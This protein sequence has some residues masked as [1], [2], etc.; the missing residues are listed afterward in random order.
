MITPIPKALFIG[1]GSTGMDILLELRNLV[2]EEFG[3]YKLPVF[4]YLVIETATV[5]HKPRDINVKKL[6]VPDTAKIQQVL[7]MPGNKMTSRQQAMTQWVDQNL[8]LRYKS[9]MDGAE[10]C[11][12]GGRL[13]LWDCWNE[14]EKALNDASD[15]LRNTENIAE[16]KRYLLEHYRKK[17]VEVKD[18]PVIDDDEPP[19][20]YVFGTLCGGTCSGMLL[21]IGFMLKRFFPKSRRFGFFTI[22]KPNVAQGME[23]PA[24]NCCGALKEINY[25]YHPETSWD[26][27]LPDGKTRATPSM[28]YTQPYEL[29]YFVSPS[30]N[31]NTIEVSQ[32]SQMLGLTLFFDSMCAHTFE[33]AGTFADMPGQPGYQETR[34]GGWSRSFHSFG[35]SALWYPKYRISGAAACEL[36]LDLCGY[37]AGHQQKSEKDLVASTKLA[38]TEWK[39]LW[40]FVQ[41]KV[42]KPGNKDQET[43]VLQQIRDVITRKV[44][45]ENL[46]QTHSVKMHTV[47]EHEELTS[48]LRLMIN[49]A[50]T[51]IA[52]LKQDIAT[53]IKTTAHHHLQRNLDIGSFTNYITQMKLLCEEET[54]RWGNVARQDAIS[55]QKLNR[56]RQREA[57]V[58]RSYAVKSLLLITPAI[59]DFR[60]DYVNVFMDEWLKLAQNRSNLYIPELLNTILAALDEMRELIGKRGETIAVLQ[61]KLKEQKERFLTENRPPNVY[62]VQ[63]LDMKPRDE[64]ALIVSNVKRRPGFSF[65]TDEKALVEFINRD[66][67]IHHLWDDL[68]AESIRDYIV[69]FYQRKTL[70]EIAHFRILDGVDVNVRAQL[71]ALANSAQ[72]Y[73]EFVNS[74]ERFHYYRPSD[75]IYGNDQRNPNSMNDLKR[76]IQEPS[77]IENCS[78][79][80]TSLEHM[81]FIYREERAIWIDSISS[82][83]DLENAYQRFVNHNDTLK[84]HTH[85]DP[86]FYDAE[87]SVR[88]RY[89]E[90]LL[91]IAGA[92]FPEQVFELQGNQY[93]LYIKDG[94]LEKPVVLGRAE[95]YRYLGRLSTGK[96][97][98]EYKIREAL[99]RNFTHEEILQR[100]NEYGKGVDLE[101]AKERNVGSETTERII[102]LSR[103]RRYLDEFVDTVLPQIYGTSIETK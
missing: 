64:A 57:K 99:A 29:I 2:F 15:S 78:L 6:Q 22:M 48:E 61:S 80:N 25:F 92:V 51:G 10:G 18:D 54:K 74:F 56:I 12:L 95:S 100:C 43:D 45:D 75:Y 49:Y 40:Q 11:R 76:L 101:L 66:H 30:N 83:V 82:Y 19:T 79:Q 41:K 103:Q 53:Q 67:N 73:L 46:I 94:K 89:I 62:F 50:G 8:F 16:A 52:G 3:V 71:N 69:E 85:R 102:Y 9:F 5:R 1:L 27:M 38:Q 59:E 65:E 4:E 47:L 32:L 81:I 42:L 98:V 84:Q 55:T 86:S 14:V 26:F 35:I 58:R 91:E 33:R 87:M 97:Q 88:T 68:S 7:S 24:A 13:I 20:I 93:V 34:K 63:R 72:P 70:A 96:E 39:N 23:S 36:G 44:Q 90:M 77:N 37:A 28:G 17:Q 21:D 31:H 60:Q